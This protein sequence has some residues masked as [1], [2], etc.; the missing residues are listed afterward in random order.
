MANSNVFPLAA[1]TETFIAPVVKANQQAVANLEKLVNFYQG[2]L[3][4]YVELGLARLKAAAEVAD[5]EG[6]KSFVEG[7]I[8]AAKTFNEKLLADS[9][10]LVA[11]VNGLA[12]EY[13]TLAKDN[14]AELTPKTLRKAA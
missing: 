6:L 13:P 10:A 14:V 12:G 5:V 2:I 9:Q 7:Q 3:P 4:G 11:L 8:E 1:Q